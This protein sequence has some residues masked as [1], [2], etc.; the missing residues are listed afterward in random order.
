MCHIF[1]IHSSD[2]GHLGYFHVLAIV[3]RAWYVAEVSVL[4]Q[5]KSQV[6]SLIRDQRSGIG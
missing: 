6:R 4:N 1:F 3:N 5:R 2:D